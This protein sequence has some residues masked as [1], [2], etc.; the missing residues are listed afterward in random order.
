MSYDDRIARIDGRVPQLKLKTAF[1]I[2]SNAVF[3]FHPIKDTNFALISTFDN[4]LLVYDVMKREVV[5][6]LE[7]LRFAPCSICFLYGMRSGE[8]RRQD[9]LAFG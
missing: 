9:L 2:K 4:D 6:Q 1:D 8:L 7:P 5:K 3:D